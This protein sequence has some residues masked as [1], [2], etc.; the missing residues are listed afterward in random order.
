PSRGKAAAF[1]SRRSQSDPATDWRR[2]HLPAENRGQML[3]EAISSKAFI[4]SIS[5]E[6]SRYMLTHAPTDRVNSKKGSIGEGLS[7]MKQQVGYLIPGSRGAVYIQRKMACACVL[8]YRDCGPGFIKIS[9]RKA[10]I[11]RVKAAFQGLLGFQ[12]HQGGINTPAEQSA[13][14]NIAF[15]LATNGSRDQGLGLLRSLRRG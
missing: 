9:I 7:R 3:V 11:E 13:E 5:G 14:R 6:G 8:G 2:H 10:Y 4:A 12:A 15:Q 1:Q